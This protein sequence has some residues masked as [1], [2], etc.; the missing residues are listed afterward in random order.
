MAV[1]QPW[2]GGPVRLVD[3]FRADGRELALAVA[4]VVPHQVRGRALLIRLVQIDGEPPVL[5]CGF[6]SGKLDLVRWSDTP[7]SADASTFLTASRWEHLRSNLSRTAELLSAEV[8]GKPSLSVKP[9]YCPHWQLRQ[10][11]KKL[12]WSSSTCILASPHCAN[13]LLSALVTHAEQLMVASGWAETWLWRQTRQRMTACPPRSWR[14]WVRAIS[15]WV[16][17]TLLVQTKAGA[18]WTGGASFS[19]RLQQLAWLDLA[20]FVHMP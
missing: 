12:P 1:R 14:R 4:A 5:A 11:M 8:C 6:S 20:V 16:N 13:Q 2:G 7:C 10:Q 15:P 18:E 17:E 9:A 3:V 19:I